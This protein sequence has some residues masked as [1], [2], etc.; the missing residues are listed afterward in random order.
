MAV[1]ACECADAE[2][3]Q[4][5]PITSE[6]YEAVRANPRRFAVLA[7]HVLLDV[8]RVV[9]RTTDYVVVEKFDAAARVAEATTL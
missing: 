6:A 5:V 3:V 1:I 7:E 4:M 2:C 9:T 8:E